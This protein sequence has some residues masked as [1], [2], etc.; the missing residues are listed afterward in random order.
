MEYADKMEICYKE[1]AEDFGI[2]ETQAERIILTFDLEDSVMDYYQEEIKQAQ[3][4]IDYEN[5]QN[6]KHYND[7]W[8]D[9]I[10]G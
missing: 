4:V 5:E 2:T 1:F 8:Q 6:K 3:E 9:H 7:G 10:G